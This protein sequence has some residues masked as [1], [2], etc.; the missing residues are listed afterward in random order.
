M[1][2]R[3][4]SEGVLAHVKWLAGALSRGGR[5]KIKSKSNQGPP[6]VQSSA[7]V[8]Q[9]VISRSRPAL[10]PPPA[11][12]P[13][14]SSPVKS[15]CTFDRL[16]YGC[17]LFMYR[18]DLKCARRARAYASAVPLSSSLRHTVGPNWS[19]QAVGAASR[20]R[21]RAAASV[22][23]RETKRRTPFSHSLT[24]SLTHSRGRV[25]YR[26]RAIVEQNS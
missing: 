1:R 23:A 22:G 14:Q 18:L 9:S 21:P 17:L 8:S 3:Y 26:P 5:L 10:T 7:P 11:R 13:V 20:A 12:S 2:H 25:A 24:H 4:S 16:P 19:A 6:P 15:I